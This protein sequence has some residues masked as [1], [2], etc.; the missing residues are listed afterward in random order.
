M[1]KNYAKTGKDKPD[2]NTIINILPIYGDDH[3]EIKKSFKEIYDYVLA[4]WSLDKMV[5]FTKW[6]FEWGAIDN[7]EWLGQMYK[8]EYLDND[9]VVKALL[10]VSDFLNSMELPEAFVEKMASMSIGNRKNDKELEAFCHSNAQ[11]KAYIEK[12]QEGEIENQR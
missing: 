9:A 3:Y 4:Y 5:Y 6:F 12:K 2:G 10:S 7:G 11:I 1:M 8:T